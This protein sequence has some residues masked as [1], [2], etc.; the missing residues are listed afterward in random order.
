MAGELKLEATIENYET[1]NNEYILYSIRV[2]LA[3]GNSLP[4]QVVRRFSDF[5]SLLWALRPQGSPWSEYELPPK[6]WFNK[7]EESFLDDRRDKLQTLLISLLSNSTVP[8]PLQHFLEVESH[9]DLDEMER[10]SFGG[11]IRRSSESPRN[12]LAVE[13]FRLQS[14]VNETLS[15][16]IDVSHVEFEDMIIDEA[17]GKVQRQLI[18][19]ELASS[20]STKK[21]PDESLIA[22]N[23]STSSQLPRASSTVSSLDGLLDT[24]ARTPAISLKD[25]KRLIERNGLLMVDAVR[26]SSQIDPSTIGDGSDLVCHMHF[27]AS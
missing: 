9:I 20:S 16:F 12:A 14:I 26:R 27:T 19:A 15:L 4:W 5:E 23:T 22:K 17:D 11:K 2:G 1:V 6:R 13:A 7:F 10:N 24:L 18:L 8:S 21:N 3:D 25:Q